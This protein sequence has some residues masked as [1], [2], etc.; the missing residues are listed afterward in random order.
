MT[1]QSELNDASTREELNAVFVGRTVIAVGE[2]QL[3]LDDGTELR[4]VPNEGGAICRCGAY[5]ITELNDCDNIIT[6]A[7]VVKDDRR[8]ARSDDG[9]HIYRLFVFSGHKKIN[10]LTVEGADNNG[11]YGTGFTINV[12]PPAGVNS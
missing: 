6:G 2:D 3:L 7:K 1:S 4:I 11:M 5:R 8:P 12:Y 9:Q 10:L